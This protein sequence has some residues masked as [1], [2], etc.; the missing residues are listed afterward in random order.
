MVE[1]LF[2]ILLLFGLIFGSIFDLKNREIPDY[3]SYSMILGSLGISLI[4]SMLTEWKFLLFAV[5]GGIIVFCL[6]YIFYY[7]K[8]IGGGDVKIFTAMGIALGNFYI[9]RVNLLIIFFII[10]LIIG[11]L[12][13]IVW[14]IV[15][16]FR[17]KKHSWMEL[18]KILIEN[19]S[20]RIIILIS[21]IV[22]LVIGI[23]FEWE[24]RLIIFLLIV[25]INILF[26]LKMFV[27][28]VERLHFVKKIKVSE[29]TEGDWLA[30]DVIHNNKILISKKEIEIEKKHIELLKKNYIYEVWIKIGIPFVP[31]ILISFIILV[32]T[33]GIL[34]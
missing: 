15:L 17:Y 27:Q 34:G 13:S 10:V 25:L 7:F 24:I 29:L 11:G 18:K 20:L 28:V 32:I 23:F 22:V 1:V 4:Y 16:F 5:L 31:A 14:G 3:L 26:Y 6:G 33:Y 8:Q 12:Y 21:S 9:G 19:K 30:K 2:G